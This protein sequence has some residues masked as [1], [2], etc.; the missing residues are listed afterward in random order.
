MSLARSLVKGAGPLGL[1]RGLSQGFV[2]QG[3]WHGWSLDIYGCGPLKAMIPQGKGLVVLEAALSGC[4]LLLSEAVGSK[5]DFVGERN[6]FLFPSKDGRALVRSIQRIL[7][8]SDGMMQKASSES[9]R[10][11]RQ[12]GLESFVRGVLSFA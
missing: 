1:R 9:I 12:I 10:L 7:S 6:G 2:R 4:V 5:D 11:G 3:A 8:L